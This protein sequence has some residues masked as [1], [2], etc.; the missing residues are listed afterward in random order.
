MG[1]AR[2]THVEQGTYLV[3]QT[4]ITPA[5]FQGDEDY[6]RFCG[7]IPAV[8]RRTH[9]R[10]HAFCLLPHA[11]YFVAQVDTEELSRFMRSLMRRCVHIFTLRGADET[12]H[13]RYRA[14]LI[15]PQL[16]LL[17]LVRYIHWLPELQGIGS[18]TEY[19]WSSYRAHLGQGRPLWLDIREVRRRFG[20]RRGDFAR[21]YTLFMAQ[22]PKAKEIREFERG[23]SWDSRRLGRSG[24]ELSTPSQLAGGATSLDII[25]EFFTQLYEVTEQEL[26]AQT[27]RPDLRQARALIAWYAPEFRFATLDEVAERLMRASSTLSQSIKLHKEQDSHVF[28]RKAW[29]VVPLTER[30]EKTMDGLPVPKNRATSR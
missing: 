9:V 21:A 26:V 17:S 1:R 14:V 22:R 28:S 18:V 15:D 4:R 2:R 13:P 8:A 20:G 3:E 12:P 30:L 10:I 24:R 7:Q 6:A 25:I 23:S 5:L 19:I 11:F 16:C 29:F 27:R